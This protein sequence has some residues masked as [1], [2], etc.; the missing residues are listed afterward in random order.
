ML[1]PR[2]TGQSLVIG[3]FCS[4]MLGQQN[5]SVSAVHGPTEFPVIMQQSVEAGKTPVGTKVRAKLDVATLVDGA[6]IPRNAVL[7][8]EV[9]E[10]TAKTATDPSRLAIRMDSVQWKNGSAQIKACLTAWYYPT[11]GEAGQNL[12]YGPPPSAKGTWNGQ[13]EYPNNSPSYKPFPGSDTQ[14]DKNSGPGAVATKTT[15]HRVFMKDMMLARSDD[16]TLVLLSKHT[17]IK[18][19]KWTTYVFA[20]SDLPAPP[21]K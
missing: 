2:I 4:A 21:K 15:D 9:I 5:P 1:T 16:G 18:L 3:I 20:G 13:G 11:T 8:G 10:S 17:N 12:Q 19:D 14:Q 7:T 6:V